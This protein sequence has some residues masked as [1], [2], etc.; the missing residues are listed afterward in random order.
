[1]AWTARVILIKDRQ[2]ATGTAKLL[3][4]C[5]EPLALPVFIILQSAVITQPRRLKL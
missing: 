5:C 3:W 4:L 1:M 2:G